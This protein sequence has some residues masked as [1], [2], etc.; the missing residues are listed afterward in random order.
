LTSDYPSTDEETNTTDEGMIWIS[1]ISHIP[2]LHI[3][4]N[5]HKYKKFLI[6][7]SCVFI[8]YIYVHF[9]RKKTK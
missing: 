6:L 5:S 7:C 8:K 9:C 4:K 1:I 2:Y 3:Y